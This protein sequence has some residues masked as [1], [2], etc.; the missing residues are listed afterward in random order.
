VVVVVVVVKM[1]FAAD[2][3]VLLRVALYPFFGGTEEEIRG[4]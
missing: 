1:I 4:K 3:P 2:M